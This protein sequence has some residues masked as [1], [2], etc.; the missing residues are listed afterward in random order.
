MSCGATLRVWE[1]RGFGAVERFTLLAMAD[2]AGPKC[3]VNGSFEILCEQTDLQFA[4]VELALNS[5]ESRQWGS[6]YV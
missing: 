4:V 3:E 5:I 1:H 2:S 6:V